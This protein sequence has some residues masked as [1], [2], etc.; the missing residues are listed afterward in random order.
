MGEFDFNSDLNCAEP[1]V[2]HDNLGTGRIKTSCKGGWADLFW[3]SEET[4]E[5]LIP[6]DAIVS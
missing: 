3:L 5:S 1:N 2:L 4:A 6:R